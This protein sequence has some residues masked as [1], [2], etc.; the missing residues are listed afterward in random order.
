M[1]M[2]LPEDVLHA[3]RKGGLKKVVKWL[4]KGSVDARNAEDGNTL[5][6]AAVVGGHP[7][8][9]RELLHR[10]ANV[11]LRN[12]DGSTP[13]MAA[14]ERGAQLQVKLLLDHSADPNRQTSQGVTALMSAMAHRQKSVLPLLLG[15]SANVDIQTVAGDTAL[16]VGA[17]YGADGCLQ[18]LLDAGADC[19]LANDEGQ[20]ALRLAEMKG[21]ASTQ[22]LLQRFT[23]QAT[24]APSSLGSKQLRVDLADH[25]VQVRTRDGHLITTMHASALTQTHRNKCRERSLS[26][27]KL[28]VE[29]MRR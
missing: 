2:A 12:D 24:L 21:H 3:A 25:Q 16:M 10:G 14:A 4:R 17:M 22:L 26:M 27:Q 29:S 19:N 5:L 23:T 15:A 7:D 18:L 1:P 11:D 28:L 13:L 8:I 20:T 6:H 9:M